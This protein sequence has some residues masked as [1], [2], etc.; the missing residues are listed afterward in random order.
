[1]ICYECER[2]IQAGVISAKDAIALNKKLLGRQIS[3][4]F[5]AE[6]L[7]EYLD[8]D[9]NDLPGMVEDFK[10]QGCSLF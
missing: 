2:E 6:C 8:I 1:M 5:C 7:A 9:K 3:R 4:F 10:L